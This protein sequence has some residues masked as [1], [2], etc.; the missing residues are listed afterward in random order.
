MEKGKKKWMELWRRL[1]EMEAENIV[2][3][4]LAHQS[5]QRYEQVKQLTKENE[6]LRRRL[7][8]LL[9]P[10]KAGSPEEERLDSWFFRT[11]RQEKA[12]SSRHG[13]DKEK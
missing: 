4:E 7:E 2:L 6:E 10:E 8:Q 13:Q 5:E 1:K 9:E 3:R 11:L 12:M